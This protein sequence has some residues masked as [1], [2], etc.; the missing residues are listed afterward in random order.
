MHIRS[1]VR[2][3]LAA[4]LVAGAGAAAAQA[5]AAG[6]STRV[7]VVSLDRILREA[8]VAQA[9]Q[10]RIESE[11]ARRD[12]ELKD[13]AGRV[14]RLQE[15]LQKDAVT[16][17]EGDRRAREREIGELSREFQRKQAETREDFE[18]RR[19]EEFGG[20]IQKADA[21]V[22]RIAESEKIDIVFQPTMYSNPRIDITE[23]VIK[24]MAQ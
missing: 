7:A 3:A 24:L 10:K 11:F 14:Q 17:S 2:A 1:M 8:P 6:G 15:A 9:A 12:Q 18:R 20:I 23:R 22:R 21:A 16:L 19:K 4:A 5:P 13:L